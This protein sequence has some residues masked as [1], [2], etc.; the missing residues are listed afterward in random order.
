MGL[1]LAARCF[2]E[3]PASA[4]VCPVLCWGYSSSSAATKTAILCALDP[5]DVTVKV[6]YWVSL[7]PLCPVCL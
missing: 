5:H 3:S 6:V 2:C 4:C 1:S 7:N